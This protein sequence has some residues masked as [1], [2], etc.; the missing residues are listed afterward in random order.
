[1]EEGAKLHIY[2][3]KVEE[4]QIIFDLT[5]S[6]VTDSPDNVKKAITVFSN[7]YD[8]IAETHAMVICTEWDEFVV[9]KPK[10]SACNTKFL[11]T[12]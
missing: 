12:E 3:P 9:R 6:E 2:D 5:S 1:L 4:S 10:I 11:H 7:P 8:A